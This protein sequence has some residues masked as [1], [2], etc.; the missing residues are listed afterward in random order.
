MPR[1]AISMSIA[2]ILKSREIL[3][4]VPDARKARAVKECLE[5]EVGPLHPASALQRHAHTAVF[6][7]APA[8]A[9]LERRTR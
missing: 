2:Q 7:D 8:A 3:C 5:G 9:L 1:R 6:L 4:I